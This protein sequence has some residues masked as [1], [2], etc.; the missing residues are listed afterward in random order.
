MDLREEKDREQVLGNLAD[1]AWWIKGYVIGR[2][3]SG[4][5]GE[6]GMDHVRALNEVMTFVR[7]QTK[8]RK[9]VP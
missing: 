1:I 3:D 6:L 7:E 4:S 5:V 2:G 8:P 9:A